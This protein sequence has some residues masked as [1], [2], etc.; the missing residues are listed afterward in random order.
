MLKG[1]MSISQLLLMV[2]FSSTINIILNHYNYWDNRF[3]AAIIGGLSTLLGGILAI[4]IIK[5]D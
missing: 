2:V 3:I 5:N 1:K 4:I